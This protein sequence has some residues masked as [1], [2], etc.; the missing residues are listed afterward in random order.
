MLRPDSAG[1]RAPGVT[2]S[3]VVSEGKGEA[4]EDGWGVVCAGAATAGAETA[5]ADAAGADSVGDG[6][7]AAA[8]S[9]LATAGA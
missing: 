2:V 1:E 6:T 7:A 4:A 3:A 9:L 5:G 8:A